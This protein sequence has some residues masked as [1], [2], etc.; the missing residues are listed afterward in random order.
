MPEFVRNNGQDAEIPIAVIS[1]REELRRVHD[2][3]LPRVVEQHNVGRGRVAEESHSGT[4]L[5]TYG[6]HGRIHATGYLHSIGGRPLI[7]G[8]FVGR[9]AR[10]ESTYGF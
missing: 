10:P 9:D 3:G 8:G 6:F 5:A 7:R 2:L 1:R 4:I